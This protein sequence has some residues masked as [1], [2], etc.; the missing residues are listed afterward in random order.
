MRKLVRIL[1][2][3]TLLVVAAGGY[4][5]W[6][7]TPRIPERP[8][9]RPSGPYAVGTREYVWTDSTRGEPYTT[10]PDD[11]RRVVVQLW[12]PAAAG[13]PGDTARYLLRREE[14]ASRLGAFAARKARTNS[15][16]DAP[17]AAAD[18]AFPVL[19]YNHGGAW[20]RWSAT[21]TTEWLASHGFVV[22][23]VEHFGFNQT[24]R[25]PDGTPFEPDTLRF[26]PETGDGRQDAL[27]SW[28]FLGDPVFL[29]WKA[30]AR[31]ALDQLEALNRE[32]G[33]FRGRLDLERV[34]AFG[35]SFGGALAVQL[36]AD[37]P[38][39]KAAVD[40]DGQLFGDVRE[41]GTTRPVLQLH[42]GVDD[43]LGYPEQDRPA[44]RELMA[45]V[46]GWDSVAR[47]RS[48][49]DWYAVTIAGT[50]HG[51]FSD[52]SLFYPRGK[53]RIEPRRAHEIINTYTLA[54]FDRYLRG[55]SGELLDAGSPPF[56]EVTLRA[57]RAAAHS[58]SV[59]SG[60]REGPARRSDCP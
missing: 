27:A 37:D 9:L 60:P 16:L 39:V 33:P 40:H 12:Y 24:V 28:A 41:R 13:A 29:I 36:T 5:L 46:A 21:F 17:V 18:G 6:R 22:A 3:V 34:G 11:R 25:F 51:D 57:W 56:P 26:P 48:T 20:T 50:D 32:P 38:R 54:F 30:D 8:F 1:L 23:S 43:A 19:L 47:A 15:V 14:F 10:R 53:D 55:G 35:W 4:F 58:C 52:L 45:M 7:I 31:F 42:H 49:A 44:V 59:A 2:V